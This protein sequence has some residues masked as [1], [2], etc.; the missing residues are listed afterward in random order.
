MMWCHQKEQGLSKENDGVGKSLAIERQNCCFV[1]KQ[2]HLSEKSFRVF[3]G[4][5]Q[6]LNFSAFSM[7]TKAQRDLLKIF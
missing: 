1:E 6:E 3:R 4:C 5:N 7:H 2:L